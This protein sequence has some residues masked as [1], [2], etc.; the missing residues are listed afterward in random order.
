MSTDGVPPAEP[1]DRP[2]RPDVAFGAP[3]P[4]TS[5]SSTSS[6][7][8][9]HTPEPRRGWVGLNTT[10]S[11]KAPYA[12]ATWMISWLVG[13]MLLFPLALLIAGGN[14]SSVSRFTPTVV[15]TLFVGT[16]TAIIVG[17]FIVSRV[18]GTGRFSFDFGLSFKPF[19]L[20]G[21]PAGILTQ[22]LVVP[23]L[24]LPLQALWPSTFDSAEVEKRASELM[25]IGSGATLA[26]LGVC[27]IVGAP[28]VEELVYRGLLQ[29]SIATAIDPVLA[30]LA[31]SLLFALVHFSWI[32][33]PGLFVAGLLFGLGVLRTD[34][35]GFGVVAHATFNATTFFIFFLSTLS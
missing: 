34:R 33:I 24:Y 17:M 22:L 11:I 28:L 21:I 2:R 1:L 4:N 18:A 30:W 20:L 19:D 5:L 14:P 25:G 27:I 23:L 9:G 3:D 6:T 32:E 8:G 10:A 13:N 7:T 31:V 16:W 26:V 12:I 15:F 35:I 29:R